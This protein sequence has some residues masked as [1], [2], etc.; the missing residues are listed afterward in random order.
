MKLYASSRVRVIDPREG[1]VLLQYEGRRG[2]VS[3]PSQPSTFGTTCVFHF[4]PR[5]FD[6][7]E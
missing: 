3:P 4:D 5:A 2:S 7:T 6:P 1:T